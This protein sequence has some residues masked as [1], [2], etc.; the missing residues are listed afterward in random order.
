MTLK[1]HDQ[2]VTCSYL[3]TAS[4]NEAGVYY[5]PLRSR[6]RFYFRVCPKVPSASFCLCLARKTSSRRPG[7]P[8]CNVKVPRDK[9]MSPHAPRGGTEEA[10]QQLAIVFGQDSR[11]GGGEGRRETPCVIFRYCI[12]TEPDPH[13]TILL[14]QQQNTS[15]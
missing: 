11:V 15:M 5:L 6:R 12:D 3:R 8:G 1:C 13:L 7:S 14:Q 10:A 4:L 2:R 9:E